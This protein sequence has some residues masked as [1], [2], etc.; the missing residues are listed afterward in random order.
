MGS[1]GRVSWSCTV[2]VRRA[3]W[4]FAVVVCPLSSCVVRCGGASFVVV[5]RSLWYVVRCG[6]SLSVVR[7]P[8]PVVFGCCSLSVVAVSFAP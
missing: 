5:R 2:L 7:W 1:G 3:S 4:S 6:A 8:S